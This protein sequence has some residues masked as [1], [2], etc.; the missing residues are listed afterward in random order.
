MACQNF[1]VRTARAKLKLTDFRM[2]IKNIILFKL[3]GVSIKGFCIPAWPQFCVSDVSIG[4]N[5]MDNGGAQI[6]K[7]KKSIQI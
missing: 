3:E 7:F 5:L 2:S 4:R 6:I 1:G